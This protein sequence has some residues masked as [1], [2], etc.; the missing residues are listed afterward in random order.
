M[1][2]SNLV[3]RGLSI[4]AVS[5]IA[6]LFTTPCFAD[7][8]VVYFS[9]QGGWVFNGKFSNINHVGGSFEPGTTASGLDLQKTGMYGAKMGIYSKRGIL[10]L[11]TEVFRTKPN[12]SRQTQTFHEP[13]FGPFI[14]RTGYDVAVTTWTLNVLARV[15]VSRRLVLYVG[16]GPAYFWSSI[17]DTAGI[18]KGGTQNSNRLGL[19]TQAGIQYFLLR[20]LAVQ[21]EYK[22]N[23]AP[24]HFPNGTNDAQGFNTHYHGHMVA[25]SAGYF[26]D[27]SLPWKI[28][29]GLRLRDLLGLPDSWQ[30]PGGR[31]PPPSD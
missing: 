1:S 15:P 19:S 21:M 14:A 9:G 30:Q 25:A 12:V 18:P 3:T 2:E 24:F 8:E 16:A 22:Y 29:R 13:T 11:E 26:F 31:K 27:V 4:L 7:D 28:P 5:F 6:I 17:K 20:N 23:F 10:G